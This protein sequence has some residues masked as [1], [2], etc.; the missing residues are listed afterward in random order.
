MGHAG[1]REDEYRDLV[2]NL[3]NWCGENHLQ[4]KG[5]KTKEMVVDFLRKKPLVC[6]GG[7]DVDIVDSYKYLCV[8]FVP[9]FDME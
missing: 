1:R 9:V 2:G 8:V 3:V 7:T 6:I 4:L 5:L